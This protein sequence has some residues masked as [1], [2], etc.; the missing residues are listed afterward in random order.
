M[1]LISNPKLN[2][3]QR[4]RSGGFSKTGSRGLDEV[5]QSGCY[6]CLSVNVSNERRDEFPKTISE[7]EDAFDGI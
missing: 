6:C 1:T 3:G 7:Y 5:N 2:A 4:T